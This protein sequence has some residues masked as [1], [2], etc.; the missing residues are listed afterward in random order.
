MNLEKEEQ[1]KPKT[2]RRKE[3]INTQSEINEIKNRKR[4]EEKKAVK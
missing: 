4:T 3:R 1:K 2:S